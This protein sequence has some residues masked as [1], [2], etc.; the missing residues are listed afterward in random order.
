M[1]VHVVVNACTPLLGIY[2]T[3]LQIKL[4]LPRSFLFLFLTEVNMFM[5]VAVTV[6]VILLSVLLKELECIT[7]QMMSVAQYLGWDVTELKPVSQTI[8]YNLL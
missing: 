6:I 8:F 3:Q 1:A 5:Y 4:T 2:F 7:Q